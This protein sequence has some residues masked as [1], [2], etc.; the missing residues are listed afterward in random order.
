MASNA[1]NFNSNNRPKN[2]PVDRAIT[3]S[4]NHT[5]TKYHITTTT[6]SDNSFI[7]TF[8]NKNDRL[9]DILNKVGDPYL[10]SSKAITLKSL[11][12]LSLSL[13]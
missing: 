13:S 5:T 12:V 6:D 3:A 10:K 8:T 7:N 4:T 11:K 2:I 1:N 9:N